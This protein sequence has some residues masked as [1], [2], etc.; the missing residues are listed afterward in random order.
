[1]RRPS[2]TMEHSTSSSGR[3]GGK[4][5]A[6]GVELLSSARYAHSQAYV[7]QLAARFGF[8]LVR[9]EEL[10]IRTEASMPLPGRIFLLQNTGRAEATRG[11]VGGGG[12]DVGR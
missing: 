3:S 1:M 2:T 8:L 7:T 5:A 4:E 11:A 6:G 10:V 12:G 9:E